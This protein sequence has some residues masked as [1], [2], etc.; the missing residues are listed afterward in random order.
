[1]RITRKEMEKRCEEVCLQ[2]SNIKSYGNK[3]PIEIW[4]KLWK[5]LDLWREARRQQKRKSDRN[6][7][8][9]NKLA[10]TVCSILD[11]YNSKATKEEKYKFWKRLWSSLNI[12]DDGIDYDKTK[13]RYFAIQTSEQKRMDKEFR[14]IINE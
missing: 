14:E 8:N 6:L 9:K 4:K 2:L 7:S 10:W 1:M 3:A 5:A 13:K 12:W 11:Q